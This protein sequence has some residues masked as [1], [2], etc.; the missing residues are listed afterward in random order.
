M[1]AASADASK[2]RRRINFEVS[3][4]RSR[5]WEVYATYKASE[6]DLALADA[7]K[8]E[9]DGGVD[10][11]KVTKETEDLATHKVECTVIFR[12]AALEREIVELAAERPK[13]AQKAAPPPPKASSPKPAAAKPAPKR[14]VKTQQVED[15][16]ILRAAPAILVSFLLSCMVGAMLTVG[17]SYSLQAVVGMGVV[18]GRRAQLA[19][20]L[21]VFAITTA[22]TLFFLLRRVMKKAMSKRTVIVRTSGQTAMATTASADPAPASSATAAASGPAVI[23]PLSSQDKERLGQAEQ[24]ATAFADHLLAHVG[25]RVNRMDAGQRFALDVYMGGAVETLVQSH[26]HDRGDFQ[27]LLQEPLRRLSAPPELI[28]RFGGL[29]EGYL[30]QPRVRA[31][32][33]LGRQDMTQLL[34]GDPHAIDPEAALQ[35]WEGAGEAANEPEVAAKPEASEEPASAEEPE[36]TEEP[37]GQFVAVL[38]TDAVMPKRLS[39]GRGRRTARRI[40]KAHAEIVRDVLAELDGSEFEH[41]GDGILASFEVPSQAVEAALKI[42][43]DIAAAQHDNKAATKL[44]ARIGIDAGES[45]HEDGELVGTTVE[46][47]SHLCHQ[48]EAGQILASGKVRDLC[49]GAELE[50]AHIGDEEIEGFAEAVSLFEI[51]ASD[52]GEQPESDDAI[53]GAE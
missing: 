38:F 18:L 17:A 11:T 16:S 12:S 23:P 1:T 10:G 2:Q 42:Q 14:G 19:V 34:A 31:V 36:S 25:E 53:E 47:A 3:V 51:V 32:Y 7:A 5:K 15:L 8:M 45:V 49:A 28:Q 33:D 24:S 26:G 4:R 13:P 37:D 6:R 52:G 50:F 30:A 48:G 41:D 9:K 43:A 21:G 46:L 29:I 22:Y 35:A 20:L 27:L 40:F 44:E 39:D